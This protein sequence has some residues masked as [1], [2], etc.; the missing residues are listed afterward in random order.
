MYEG[1]RKVYIDVHE[2]CLSRLPLFFPPLFL[3][4]PILNCFKTHGSIWLATY[5]ARLVC[6]FLIYSLFAIISTH[7]W[8]IG[9]FL[10]LYKA[11]Y[12]ISPLFFFL[13]FF[14]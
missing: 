10:T 5:L 9:H 8:E 6:I 12:S 1:R 4:T 11:L 13:F 14:S 2:R 3:S 7:L